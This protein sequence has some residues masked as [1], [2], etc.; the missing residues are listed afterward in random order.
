MKAEALA[1]CETLLPP[2]GRELLG[3]LGADD[4]LR[5][6]NKFKGQKL[7]I[8]KRATHNHSLTDTISGANLERLCRRF[9]DSYLDVPQ[10]Q[11]AM[12]EMRN[13]ALIEDYGNKLSRNELCKKYGVSVRHVE[14]VLGRAVPECAV[15]AFQDD[16]FGA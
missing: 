12:L 6:V 8:P 7:W 2:V 14:R 4:L 16:L 15:S 9:G 10:C 11:R 13:A 5:L 1:A 3:L